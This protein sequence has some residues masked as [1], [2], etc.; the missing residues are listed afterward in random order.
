LRPWVVILAAAAGVL[1][2]VGFV[3]AVDG[4]D[5]T[6]E[7]VRADRWADD[8]C[9][10]VGAWE[11]QLEAIGDDLA[12]NNFAARENDGGSGD[13]VEATIFVR[14]AIDR[15][16]DATDQTLQEGLERSGIPDVANGEQATRILDA[17]AQ[18]TENDLLAVEDTLDRS[19][20]TPSAAYVSLRGAVTALERS[21]L[22][23]RAAFRQVAALD[24]ELADALEESGNCEE[25]MR[26]EP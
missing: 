10:A 26:E 17:W 14:E 8:V 22:A 1:V 21:A 2:L 24:P 9:G 18:S 15:A 20:D 25:L 5:N 16:V 4:R 6:G 11:G 12:E 3:A 7:T 23:G 13:H 19:P